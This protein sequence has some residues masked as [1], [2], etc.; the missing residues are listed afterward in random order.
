MKK[1]RLDR[2]IKPRPSRG[3]R[4]P[5]L[6]TMSIMEVPHAHERSRDAFEPWAL[7]P[8]LHSVVPAIG[9]ITDEGPPFWEVWFLHNHRPVVLRVPSPGTGDLQID[10]LSDYL[11]LSVRA[12]KDGTATADEKNAARFARRIREYACDE[13]WPEPPPTV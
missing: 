11:A 1:P 5:S 9:H 10:E 7:R 4:A 13:H 8:V 12:E 2:I 3:E 6:T